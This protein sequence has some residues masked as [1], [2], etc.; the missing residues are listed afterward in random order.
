MET[1]GVQSIKKTNLIIST[2]EELFRRSKIALT[3]E[4]IRFDKNAYG[5]SIFYNIYVIEVRLL[6]KT[7]KT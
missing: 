6:Q 3:K 2:F 4:L 1:A 7:T 5:D